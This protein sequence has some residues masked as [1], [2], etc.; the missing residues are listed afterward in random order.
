MIWLSMCSVRRRPAGPCRSSRWACC[1]WSSRLWSWSRG[2]TAASACCAAG[3][4]G[5]AAPPSPPLPN[6]TST[7]RSAAFPQPCSSKSLLDVAI[8]C[9][10]WAQVQVIT[11]HVLQKE[12]ERT[13]CPFASH[14]AQCITVHGT[15]L[16]LPPELLSAP[17]AAPDSD[18]LAASTY[19]G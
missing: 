16:L 15:L 14:Q 11:R 9:S 4:C 12:W 10:Q 8:P 5:A 2:L 7:G 18:M 1:S 17:K 6:L 19:C 3:P 13:Y